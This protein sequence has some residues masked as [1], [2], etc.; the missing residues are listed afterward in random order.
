MG[1]TAS[2]SLTSP[3]TEHRK[4]TPWMRGVTEGGGEDGGLDGVV[5]DSYGNNIRTNDNCLV[6]RLYVSWSNCDWNS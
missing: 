5:E 3:I 2:H 6:I 4:P 1:S